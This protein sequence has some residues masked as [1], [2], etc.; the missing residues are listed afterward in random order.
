ME[1]MMKPEPS[2]RPFAFGCDVGATKIA[3]TLGL[4]PGVIADRLVDSTDRVKGPEA[5]IK[6]LVSMI[7]MMT[8]K[9]KLS[10]KNCLGLGVGFAGPVNGKMGMVIK[11]ANI[12]GW[13]NYPLREKLQDALSLPVCVGND[14]NVGA[15][16]EYRYGGMAR[17]GDM[18]YI[19]ISSG[20]GA[21]IVLDGK[22]YEGTNFT[23]GEIGHVTIMDNGARCGCGKTGCL[24]T[25]A[26]GLGIERIANERM[27]G[28]ETS[29]RGRAAETGGRVSCATVFQEAR[30][31]DILSTE[32]VENACRYLGRAIAAAVMLMGFSTIVLGGGLTK[33]GEFLRKKVDFYTRRQLSMIPDE[34]VGIHISRMPESVVDIG[35]LDM[36]FESAARR[37]AGGETGKQRLP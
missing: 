10:M 22:L 16:G 32:I 27:S 2:Q 11:G 20:I 3:L 21:G 36:I 30:S 14:A 19:T 34:M 9:N 12:P 28:E 4:E 8:E 23:A 6:S 15:L 13:E 5:L 17:R 35:A 29:L 24:E 33:E 18:L 37:N 1:V 26:S 31:G 7:R 25:V